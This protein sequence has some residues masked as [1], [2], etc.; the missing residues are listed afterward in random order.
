MKV[1]RREKKFKLNL[2]NIREYLTIHILSVDG[3]PFKCAVLFQQSSDSLH[4]DGT[5][6]KSCN[7]K[8]RARFAALAADVENFEC[9]MKPVRSKES[10][11]KGPSPR[12]SC[13]DVI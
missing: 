7:E 1:K 5:V 3:F 12:L 2:W 11:L 8:L 13:G 10:F 6:D 9:D 4:D